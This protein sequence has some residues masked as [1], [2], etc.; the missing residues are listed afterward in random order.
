VWSNGSCHSW[1]R[2]LSDALWVTLIRLWVTSHSC[3]ACFWFCQN[4]HNDYHWSGIMEFFSRTSCLEE[5]NDQLHW[6][7]QLEFVIRSMYCILFNLIWAQIACLSGGVSPLYQLMFH[8][9]GNL[10]FVLCFTCGLCL[11][12]YLFDSMKDIT[13]L[14]CGHTMHLECMRDMHSHAQ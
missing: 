1:W 14:P 7:L 4:W 11:V 3:H 13:V 8:Q 10:Q 9:R 12:Q 6:H 5:K 2:W